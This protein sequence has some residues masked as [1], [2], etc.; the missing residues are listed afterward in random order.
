MGPRT[1]GKLSVGT[2]ASLIGYRHTLDPELSATLPRLFRELELGVSTN[3]VVVQIL[4]ELDR[5]LTEGALLRSESE[6]HI[7]IPLAVRAVP[8]D[9]GRVEHENQP[10]QRR[11]C[12]PATTRTA[13]SGARSCHS[14]ITSNDP[15]TLAR[16]ISMESSAMT[17]RG[18]P[19]GRSSARTPR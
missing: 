1:R 5:F 2:C 8:I 12:L 14:P 9:S 6:I 11:K 10:S 3:D 16:T 13:H 15:R 19:N 7:P 18:R 4:S 17:N